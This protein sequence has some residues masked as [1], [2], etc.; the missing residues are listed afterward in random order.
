MKKFWILA[1]LLWG[2]SIASAGEQLAD[3][4]LGRRLDFVPG[5]RRD[6]GKQQRGNAEHDVEPLFARVQLRVAHVADGDADAVRLEIG[7]LEVE[8][9]AVGEGH[10]RDVKIIDVL[11]FRDLA[12]GTEVTV[13]PLRLSLRGRRGGVAG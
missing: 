4:D 11:A 6:R 1:L 3:L 13:S 2:T 7:F 9:D 10:Q 12:R 5:D 8:A